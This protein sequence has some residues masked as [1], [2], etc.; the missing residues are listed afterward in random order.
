MRILLI[1]DEKD[2][3][4]TIRI[5]FL[6]HWPDVELNVAEDGRSGIGAAVQT[7]PDLII[8]DIGLPDID[9]YEVCRELRLL[10]T[11]P[12]VILTAWGSDADKDRSLEAGA[13]DYIPKP[14]GQTDLLSRVRSVWS[15]SRAP[16]PVANVEPVEVSG[17]VMDFRSGKVWRG[18]Q[19]VTLT[20]TEY[21][22][23]FHLARNPG[24][25]F[26][27]R[28]LLAKVWGKTYIEELRHI[29]HIINSLRNKVEP[30]PTQP[31][32]LQEVVGVG[33]KLELGTTRS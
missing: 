19:M 8:L 2:I 9:G 33:Y 4:E 15:R 29:R 25:L 27:Y 3:I 20:N 11:M 30:I 28:S 5:C 16:L 21:S 17:L 18:G 23:L 12:I 7:N 1:E 6:I 24:L 13:D 26:P 10:F 31:V 14:F 22:V 32:I